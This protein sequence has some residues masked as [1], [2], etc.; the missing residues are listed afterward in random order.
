MLRVITTVRLVL[1]GIIQQQQAILYAC[2]LNRGFALKMENMEPKRTKLKKIHDE[3]CL[4]ECNI[5]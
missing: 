4:T 3:K 2:T 5:V 1:P